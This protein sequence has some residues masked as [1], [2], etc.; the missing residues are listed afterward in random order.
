MA[1]LSKG[2]ILS[3]DTCVVAT[4]TPIRKFFFIPDRRFCINPRGYFVIGIQ[5]RFG[6]EDR[7]FAVAIFFSKIVNGDGYREKIQFL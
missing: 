3:I 4:G 7:K 5:C 6:I 1:E 2:F